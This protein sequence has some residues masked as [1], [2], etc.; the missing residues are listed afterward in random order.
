MNLDIVSVHCASGGTLV[1]SGNLDEESDFLKK[2]LR[3][4]S[5]IQKLGCQHPNV[6]YS[7]TELGKL[8]QDQGKLKEALEMQERFFDLRQAIFGEE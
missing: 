3:M 7:I 5:D 8:Y 2:G 4:N 1:I 6:A